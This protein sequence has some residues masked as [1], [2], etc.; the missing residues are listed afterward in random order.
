MSFSRKRDR[1]VFF[2][3]I[4]IPAAAVSSWFLAKSVNNTGETHYITI[5]GSNTVFKIIDTTYKAFAEYHSGVIISVTGSGTGSGIT[6]LID[7]QADIAM[8]SRPY[9]DTEQ[10]A[11]NGS[12]NAVAFA[13]DALTIITHASAN[14]LDLTIDV[15]RAI[16][17]G[18]ISDW[19]DPLVA[20]AGLTGAIQVVVR[21][22][23]SGTRDAFNELVMGD[24]AQ[25][26][27]GSEY[28]SSAIQKSS[29]Q[30]IKDAVAANSNYVG[31]IGLGYLDS[32]VKAVTING[33]EPTLENVLNDSYFIQR[34]LF[35]ITLGVPEGMVYEFINWSM[36]PEGQDLVLE[37]GFIN[38]APTTDDVFT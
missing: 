14:P 27:P 23:G 19:S 38:V 17:N 16:F 26:E 10:T 5:E 36:S 12:L 32:T 15:A 34:E 11:A 9:K 24:S 33:V 25:I 35:L 2:L 20:S 29:N 30:L 13:K 1:L 31:Y 37:T 7:E 6:A 18:T 22:S 21:E 3:I 28:V 8:A 4:L